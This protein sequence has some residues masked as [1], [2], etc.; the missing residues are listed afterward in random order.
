QLTAEKSGFAVV[1]R[2]NVQLQ[3]NTPTT[4]DVGMDLGSAV[5]VVNVE[6]EATPINT[7]DPSIGNAFSERQ[8]RQLPLG[9]RNVVELL[10]LQVGVTPTGEVLGARRDQNN[11]TL[12]GAD[13]NNKQK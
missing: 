7:V 13:V 9:T 3:V 12:D 6:A 1:T 10:S 5:D 8:V 4:L 2:E 11:I